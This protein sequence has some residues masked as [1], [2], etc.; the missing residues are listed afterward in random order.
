MFWPSANVWQ[1]WAS[2]ILLVRRPT[3][4]LLAHLGG[5]RRQGD[6]CGRRGTLRLERPVRTATFPDDLSVDALP[7]GHLPLV[8]ARVDD[9]GITQALDEL[10]PKAPRSKGS[11]ADCVVAMARSILGGW[12]A[13]H[14]M[15]PWTD[16][17]LGG[18]SD[19]PP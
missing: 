14:R 13:R 7:L 16:Q 11:D 9:L 8:T 6:R 17:A 12:T 2:P 3:G 19:R 5:R 15:E 1:I 18:R 4:G 10:L